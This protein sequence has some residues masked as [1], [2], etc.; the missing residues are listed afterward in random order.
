MSLNTCWTRSGK[1]SVSHSRNRSRILSGKRSSTS[2]GVAHAGFRDCFEDALDLGIMIAG[3]TALPKSSWDSCLH[4]L[5]ERIEPSRRRGS[6]RLHGAGQFRIDRRHRDRY[7][8]QIALGHAYEDVEIAQHQR[9]FGYD[10]TGWPARS[11]TSRMR[12]MI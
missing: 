12:R 4:Q 9:R 10:A 6:A 5:P 8:D 3:M 11:S 2:A 7:L 1:F